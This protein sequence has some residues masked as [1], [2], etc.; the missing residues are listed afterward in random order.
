MDIEDLSE[1]SD[2]FEAFLAR[3]ADL[4]GRSE[5][6]EQARKYVRGL[7]APVGRKN[8]WQLAEAVGD[9]V[10]DR[11]QRLLYRNDWDVDEARDRLRAFMV[12]MFGEEDAIIVIDETGF[13]KKGNRSVGVKRQYSGTAG[14]IENCQIGVFLS[15]ATSKGHGFL[16]RRLYLPED[17]CGDPERRERAKVPPEIRFE[18]KGELAVDM[19]ERA[20]AEGVPARWVTGDEVYGDTTPL[21]DAVIRHGCLYVLAVSRS[22]PVWEEMP[23]VEAPGQPLTGRPR[24][25]TRLAPGAPRASRADEIVGTWREERWQRFSVAE[26]E[27]GPR[28]YDWA[29]QR[30]IESRERLPGPEAWLLVR[31]SVSDPTDMA[32]FLSNAPPDT[33]LTELAKVAATR[34]VVEQCIEEAKGETGLDEYEVRHWHSWHRHITLSM[35]AHSWLASTRYKAELKRGAKI[36][37]S[38]S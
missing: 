7:L 8:G 9:A 13:I 36:R 32:Y 24:T 6:R 2:D 5:P 18:T 38:P 30:V 17:W 26:G 21:R 20:W 10:P 35:M 31:R 25:K 37:S 16:D 28:I 3:F 33:P 11:M 34:Y 29:R 15:Y 4:F 22:A 12:E 23:A 19:L 14:K 1:W 27:K